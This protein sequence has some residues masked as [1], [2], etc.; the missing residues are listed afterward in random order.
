[1][2]LGEKDYIIIKTLCRVK[3][4][5]PGKNDKIKA[6]LMKEENSHKSKE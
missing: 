6:F 1:M 3:I 5:C 4:T 2:D